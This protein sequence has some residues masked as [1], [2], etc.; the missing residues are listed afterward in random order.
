MLNSLSNI[1]LILLKKAPA[2]L[3]IRIKLLQERCPGV[4]LPKV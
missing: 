3:Q 4:T 2:K 1:F